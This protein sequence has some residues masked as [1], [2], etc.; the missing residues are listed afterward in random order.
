MVGLGVADNDVV[1]LA[2]WRNGRGGLLGGGGLGMADD[3]VVN[4]VAWEKRRE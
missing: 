1:D 3:D 4:L 2:A